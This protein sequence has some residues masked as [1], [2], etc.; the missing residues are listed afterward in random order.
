MT[1]TALSFVIPSCDITFYIIFAM[2]SQVGHGNKTEIDSTKLAQSLLTYLANQ[3]EHY[4]SLDVITIA[5]NLFPGLIIFISTWIFPFSDCRYFFLVLN[6]PVALK[7]K[8]NDTN[9]LKLNW[10]FATKIDFDGRETWKLICF[11]D[12]TVMFSL[13]D[14]VSL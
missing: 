7:I 4:P 1:F 14:W 12:N 8:Q 5:T 13:V 9:L 3:I 11:Y 2:T 6:C 10:Y